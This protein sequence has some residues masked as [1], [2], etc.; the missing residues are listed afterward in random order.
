MKKW[1]LGI[2]LGGTFI[3]F[4]AMDAENNHCETFQ[5]PTPSDRDG[6]IGQMISGARQL[7]ERQGL[8]KRDILGVGIGS[9]GPLDIKNGVI[10]S[11]PNLPGLD[12]LPIRDLVSEGLDL[13]TVVENDA[14]AAAFGEYICGAGEG[15]AIMILL[16]LGTGIGSGIV[17]DGK[18]LHGSN[19]IGGELGHVIIEPAGMVCSCGQ[20]GCL[21]RYCSAGF[22]AEQAT[23]QIEYDERKS[24]LRAIL[25]EKGSIDARDINDAR[26]SGD[27]LAVEVWDQ[28]AYYLALAS[29]NICRIF[30][31]DEIVFAGG[32]TNAGDDLMAPLNEHFRRLYWKFTKPTVKL[33]IAQLGSDAGSIG[34]AG[35]AWQ[36]FG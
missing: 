11:L 33:A 13:P 35:V 23:R 18:I 1:C 36:A 7:M 32:M 9:P 4:V 15:A 31:P 5:L 14:N 12:N 29:V 22:I 8:T 24:S 34:A 30:D 19:G 17:I 3:K 27:D 20:N 6:I 21:E 16:T 10:I 26:K 25:K 28:A 2:D